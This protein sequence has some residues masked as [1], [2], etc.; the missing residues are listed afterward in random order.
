MNNESPLQFSVFAKIGKQS[1]LLALPEH[2]LAGAPWE[3]HVLEALGQVDIAINE[4]E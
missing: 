4:T 1:S 3:L 2:L